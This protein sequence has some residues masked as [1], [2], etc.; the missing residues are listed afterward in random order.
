MLGKD[1]MGCYNTVEIW[2]ADKVNEL[3]GSAE[4]GSYVQRV[5]RID[6]ITPYALYVIARPC[7]C[8]N[9][10]ESGTDEEANYVKFPDSVSQEDRKKALIWTHEFANGF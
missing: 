6:G 4:T 1:Q 8:G 9:N 10:G 5:E 7:L 3:G 2:N